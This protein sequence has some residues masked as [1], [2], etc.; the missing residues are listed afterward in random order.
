[1]ESYKSDEIEIDL[2]DLTK[3][4]LSRWYIFVL[5]II[6]GT[7]AVGLLGLMKTGKAGTVYSAS[8]TYHIGIKNADGGNG[9]SDDVLLGYIGDSVYVS[10]S[11]SVLDAV[12]EKLDLKCEGRDLLNS[13]TVQRVPDS[14]YV[15]LTVRNT[16]EKMAASI[17]DAIAGETCRCMTERNPGINAVIYDHTGPEPVK[18]ES[19][20]KLMLCGGILGFLAGLMLLSVIYVKK[21]IRK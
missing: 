20:G 7:G 18:E 8:V 9:L 11:Q 12:V 4:Y 5:A 17:A 15:V 10:G 6:V 14:Y 19:S 1:M 3:Y 16:D 21:E 13:L 2:M